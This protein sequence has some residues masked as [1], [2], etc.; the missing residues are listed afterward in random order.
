LKGVEVNLYAII[1]V[2]LL[3]ATCGKGRKFYQ[4]CSHNREVIGERESSVAAKRSVKAESIGDEG[5]ETEFTK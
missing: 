1:Q 4:I 5:R 2:T 3:G